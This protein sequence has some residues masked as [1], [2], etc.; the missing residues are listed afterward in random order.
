MAYTQVILKEKITGLGAE[1]DVVKV[2]RGFA[3]NFLLPQNKAMEATKRNLAFTASLKATRAKREAE[4][5]AEAEK[6]AAKIKKLKLSMTLAIGAQGKAF[7]SIT[8]I[9]IAKAL[10]EQHGVK[11]DRHAIQLEKPIKSSGKFDVNVKLHPEVTCFIKLT[12]GAE[13]GA[14]AADT[15]EEGQEA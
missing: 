13:G 4:E 12:V 9:D 5:L 11:L 3:R 1:A 14:E 8:T 15:D 2:R 10:Q 7:G 6:M